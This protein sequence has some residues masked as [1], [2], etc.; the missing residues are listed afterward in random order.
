VLNSLREALIGG[1]GWQALAIPML[2]LLPL[3]IASVAT[4]IFVFRFFLRCERRLGTLGL[5]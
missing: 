1:A 2:E 4:G 5:Y 3:A